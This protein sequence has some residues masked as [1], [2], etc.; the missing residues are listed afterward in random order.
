MALLLQRY[1][2]AQKTSLT[3]KLVALNQIYMYMSVCVRLTMGF[4]LV[5]LRVSLVLGNG[6]S[7]C[8]L[9][10]WWRCT[11]GSHYSKLKHNCQILYINN[12]LASFAYI[13]ICLAFLLA[14]LS[15]NKTRISSLKFKKR[16]ITYT[17]IISAVKVK[18]RWE[19]RD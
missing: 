8:E 2:F 4:L 15:Q 5:Y 19:F 11:V 14:F 16:F 7:T 6:I 13:N 18:A 9:H 17:V 1:N 3:V 12:I 10:H